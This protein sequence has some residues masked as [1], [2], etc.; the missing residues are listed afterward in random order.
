MI[1]QANAGVGT[2]AACMQ[3]NAGLGEISSTT[4]ITLG[5]TVGALLTTMIVGASKKKIGS[6]ALGTAAGALAGWYFGR[7][8]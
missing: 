3:A 7:T 8:A 1:Y 2:C 4:R 5:A 6:I